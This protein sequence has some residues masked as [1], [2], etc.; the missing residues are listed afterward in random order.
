MLGKP[1]DAKSCHFL[2]IERTCYD[3]LNFLE[4]DGRQALYVNAA[5]SEALDVE[6]LC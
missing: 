1:G 5:E 2:F 3:L 4:S 6:H